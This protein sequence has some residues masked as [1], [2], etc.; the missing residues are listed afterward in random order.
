MRLD[1][2]SEVRPEG[3][4]RYRLMLKDGTTLI[5]SRTPADAL[6]RLIL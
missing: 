3:S 4:S 6:R 1:Q 5:V 2:I